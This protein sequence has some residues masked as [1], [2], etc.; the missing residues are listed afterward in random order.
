M[1][2]ARVYLSKSTSLHYVTVLRHDHFMQ[3]V[4]Q[5]KQAATDR[6]TQAVTP[7]DAIRTACQLLDDGFEVCGI[8]TGSLTHIIGKDEI[9]RLYDLWVKAKPP[10][11]KRWRGG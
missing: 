8:G 4:V 3:W 1:K 2:S 10:Y 9:S 5:Y 11:S 6:T 7:E